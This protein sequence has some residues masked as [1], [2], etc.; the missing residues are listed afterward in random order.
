MKVAIV[1]IRRNTLVVILAYFMHYYHIDISHS[2]R[3][4]YICAVWLNNN[5][6][7]L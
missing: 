3:N 2:V 5:S 6:Y 1:S 4:Y 7:L